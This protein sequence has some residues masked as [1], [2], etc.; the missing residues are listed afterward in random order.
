MIVLLSA[1]QAK[2]GA[3]ELSGVALV[4]VEVVNEADCAKVFDISGGEDVLE[5]KG[6]PFGRLVGNGGTPTPEIALDTAGTT[7]ES[8]LDRAGIISVTGA[9]REL[10]GI[11]PEGREGNNPEGNG[12]RLVGIAMLGNVIC[13]MFAVWSVSVVPPGKTVIKADVNWRALVLDGAV[14]ELL[15]KVE[16]TTALLARAVDEPAGGGTVDD[17]G[18]NVNVLVLLP[19]I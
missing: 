13:G 14:N 8:I 17:A 10:M 16:V 11:N 18:F 7:G 1:G 19:M 3:A 2:L 5:L 6:K 12:G 15:L 9:S 4:A